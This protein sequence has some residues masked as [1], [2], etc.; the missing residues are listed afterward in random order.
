MNLSVKMTPEDV[1]LRQRFEAELRHLCS[2]KPCIELVI[3]PQDA[4]LI[5]SFLQLALRHPTVRQFPTVARVEE[6]AH[7]IQELVAPA[8]SALDEVAQRG[9]LSE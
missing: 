7:R 4:W 8:G 5:L 2:T 1:E 6:I 9:W 3:R